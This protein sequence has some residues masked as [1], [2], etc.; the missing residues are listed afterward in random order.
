MNPSASA[1]R[2][3]VANVIT[4]LHPDVIVLGGSVAAIGPLLTDTVWATVRERVRM[5]PLEGIRIV[6]SDL[7]QRAGLLGGI[8]L[9]VR[10]GV[11]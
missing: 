9:A 7:G 6:L 8:A 3:E 4:V 10:G 1:R 5:F 11:V 2:I